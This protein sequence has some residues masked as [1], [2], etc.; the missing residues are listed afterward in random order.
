[1]RGRLHTSG[2]FFVSFAIIVALTAFLSGAGADEYTAAS[3]PIEA[4]NISADDVTASAKAEQ[5][6]ASSVLVKVSYQREGQSQARLF[7]IPRELAS[8]MDG[9]LIGALEVR[10]LV[11]ASNGE[12]KQLILD[13]NREGK[14]VHEVEFQ[15]GWSKDGTKTSCN[16]VVQASREGKWGAANEPRRDLGLP[17]EDSDCRHY[18]FTSEPGQRDAKRALAGAS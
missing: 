5:S 12:P 13:E 16:L 1:M 6:N 17:V 11:L 14:K 3:G 8:R 4:M 2:F 18:I 15:V 9:G 10:S 7:L